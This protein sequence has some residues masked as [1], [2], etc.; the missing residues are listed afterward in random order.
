MCRGFGDMA[1][2]G[3]KPTS[4]VSFRT[5]RRPVLLLAGCAA[6]AA[7]ST[8]LPWALAFDPEAWLVWGR[9]ITHG[10]LVTEGGPSW[11]PLPVA[12]DVPLALL[13]DAAPWAWLV[14]ARTAG[15][16]ALAGAF[17]LARRLAGTGWAAAALIALSPWWAFHTALGNSEGMLAA[18][19]LWAV[20]AHLDGRRGAAL[21]LG[22]AAA[23]LRPE[24]W[25]FL[26]VY[27]LW[28]WRAEPA[29]RARIVAALAAV[30]LAWCV[31]ELLSSGRPFRAAEAARGTPSSE[32]AARAD[33]PFIE[34]FADAAQLMTIPVLVAAAFAARRAPRLALGALA[35]VLLV[36]VM[37][38]AGFAGT[39]RYS[40]PAAAVAAVL[41]ATLRPVLAIVVVV[42][43]AALQLGPLDDQRADIATRVDLR[44][45]I[46]NDPCSAPPYAITTA[47][48]FADEAIR[49]VSRRCG[50]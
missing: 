27:A 30:P 43:V 41:A 14:V 34:V 1:V 15:L 40:V 4:A 38:A 35:W 5:V 9:E 37:T 36:A 7:L 44:E 45:R 48:W 22:L 46:E 28:L 11:K 3:R 23:L 12:I 2:S 31:P 19:V 16:L 8:L 32:A 21:A 25:P 33:V 29:L 24:A 10:E 39:P 17:L 18:A 20:V 47:A 13:G 6:L 42:I 26:G 50:R 49:D